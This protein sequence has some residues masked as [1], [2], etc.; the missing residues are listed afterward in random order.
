MS[1]GQR[2]LL[3]EVCSLIKLILVMPAMNAASERSFSALRWVKMY[4]RSAMTRACLNH[5]M[6]L[7]VHKDRTD[8]LQ[9]AA[10]ANQFVAG[11]EHQLSLFGKF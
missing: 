1:P 9:P 5:Q 11:S 2:E 4:L 3:P 6:L 7:H 10:V 8:R